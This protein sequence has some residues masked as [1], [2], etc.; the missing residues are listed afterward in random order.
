ME[1]EGCK[2]KNDIIFKLVKIVTVARLD[3]NKE[4]IE[5]A[6]SELHPETKRSSSP[7]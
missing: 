4:I 3:R 2:R 7:S 5:E 6:L 1:C